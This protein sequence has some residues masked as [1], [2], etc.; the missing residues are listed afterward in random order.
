MFP[1]PSITSASALHP[2]PRSTIFIVDS[3]V[4]NHN[5]CSVCIVIHGEWPN[6]DSAATIATIILS[7]ATSLLPRSRVIQI[8]RMLYNDFSG[9]PYRQYT[10]QRIACQSTL[11]DKF[12]SI[13]LPTQACPIAQINGDN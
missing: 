1:P 8:A 12:Y 7:L 11:K 4:A 3:F 6:Y 2:T 9:P 10:Q 5:P 13:C